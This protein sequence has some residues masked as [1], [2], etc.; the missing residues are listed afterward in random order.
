MREELLNGE[1]I[2]NALEGQVLV[3]DWR[4][5]FNELRP[6]RSLQIATPSEFAARWSAE[7]EIKVS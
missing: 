2:E 3:D 1:L 4:E 7:H 5:E 6:H